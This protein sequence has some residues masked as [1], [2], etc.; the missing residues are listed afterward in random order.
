MSV[1]EPPLTVVVTRSADDNASLGAELTRR[2]FDVV[3]VPLVAILAPSD[4]GEALA[5]AVASIDDGTVAWVV[6]TSVNGVDALAA[7]LATGRGDRRWPDRVEVAA[8]G[9]ATAAA[10]RAAGMTVGIVPPEATAGSLVEVFPNHGPTALRR[11]V[12]APLAELAGS[13]VED[14]LRAKGW[15][16][17]R[18]EAY[19]TGAPSGPGP[20][21]PTVARVSTA[22]A[23]TFFSPSVVD[24]WIAQFGPAAP[25]VVVCI[26]PSTAE[27]ARDRG[28]TG[29]VMARPHTEDGVIEALSA[30]LVD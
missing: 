17:E 6:L 15:S 12:L 10:A 8:V 7:A 18:V 11:R 3:A 13:T 29:V 21:A 27:R 24:R 30:A 9:P 26:G 16:V 22:D 14:G 2:G 23:V 1:P 20:D 5:R 28:L 25:P 4:G 19:R